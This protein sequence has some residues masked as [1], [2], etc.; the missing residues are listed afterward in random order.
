MDRD[1]GATFSFSWAICNCPFQFSGYWPRLMPFG[2][3]VEKPERRRRHSALV[4]EFSV[5]SLLQVIRQICFHLFNLR[6]S[7]FSSKS[8]PAYGTNREM[9]KGMKESV[10]ETGLEKVSDF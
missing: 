10:A 2:D 4:H 6:I 9:G 3:V 8:T 7:C 1:A 5:F